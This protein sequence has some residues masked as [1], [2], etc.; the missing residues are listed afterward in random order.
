[1]SDMLAPL[2]PAFDLETLVQAAA[3]EGS[4]LWDLSRVTLHTEGWD[5]VVLE[6]ADGW[7]LRF[8]REDDDSFEHEA[9]NRGTSTRAVLLIEIWRPEIDAAEQ[10]AL[11]RV[12][13]A[14]GGYRGVEH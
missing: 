5:N 13:E 2:A 1:M 9:W 8:P 11:G 10:D 6:T 7:I 4:G 3:V 14:I 12:F